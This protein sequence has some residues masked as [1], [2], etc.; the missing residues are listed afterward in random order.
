MLDTHTNTIFNLKLTLM[1]GTAC[2]L[3]CDIKQFKNKKI[4]IELLMTIAVEVVLV[5]VPYVII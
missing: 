1:Y 2:C 4:P 5:L 3:M